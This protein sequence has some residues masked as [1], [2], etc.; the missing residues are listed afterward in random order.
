[1]ETVTSSWAARACDRPGQEPLPA[2]RHHKQPDLAANTSA[3]ERAPWQRLGAT[4]AK[5]HFNEWLRE[6]REP[7]IPAQC[8]TCKDLKA[9][10]GDQPAQ[11]PW[12]AITETGI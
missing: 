6:R 7:L 12:P 2:H 11:L 3:P 1:M 4:E 8:F 5:K 9:S 10:F